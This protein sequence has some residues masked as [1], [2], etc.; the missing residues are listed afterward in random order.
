[1]DR[2]DSTGLEQ[3]SIQWNSEGVP[4]AVDMLLERRNSPRQLRDIDAD[5]D[6][7]TMSCL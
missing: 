5:A 1:M 3:F 6:D 7:D 4:S 2:Q